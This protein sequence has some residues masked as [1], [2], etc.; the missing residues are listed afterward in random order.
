[1]PAR[2]QQADHVRQVEL[3]LR[4]LRLQLSE[5]A[6]E[7]GHLEDIQPGVDL[8]DAPDVVRRVLGLD[9]GVHAALVVADDAPV[10]SRIVQDDGEERGCRAALA[11]DGQ[12]TL[13][14]LGPQQG[15]VAVHDQEC[16]IR[17]GGER[18]ARDLHGMA[19]AE[20]GLLAHEGQAPAR[21][22][23]LHGLRLVP[24]HHRDGFGRRRLDGA[25]DV[26][27]EGHAQD[28]VEDLGPPALHARA[29]AR[30]QDD[31]LH[32][33]R[34]HRISLAGRCGPAAGRT[35]GLEVERTD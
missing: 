13:K 3:A 18:L 22:R 10:R 9:D 27:E 11:V 28:R 26:L 8:A 16:P 29:L 30:G 19:G 7:R 1:V 23:G 21:E 15:N 4:V 14:G 35:R 33:M 24:H 34:A 25:Q 32:G 12:E 31:G 20:R 5:D 2:A 6:E 17:V